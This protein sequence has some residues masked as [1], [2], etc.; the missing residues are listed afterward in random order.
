LVQANEKATEAADSRIS[1]GLIQHG[2]QILKS[3]PS[4]LRF[5]L[6]PVSMPLCRAGAHGNRARSGELDRDRN[7]SQEYFRSVEE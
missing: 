6:V 5:R 1:R 4:L 7:V 3:S 2:E